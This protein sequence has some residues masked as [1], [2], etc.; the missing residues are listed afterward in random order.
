KRDGRHEHGDEY[1]IKLCNEGGQAE[2][3]EQDGEHRCYATQHRQRCA[4][5]AHPDEL[6]IVVQGSVR[7]RGC[8]GLL[9]GGEDRACL[10]GPC[11]IDAAGDQAIKRFAHRAHRADLAFE[12]TLLLDR[13]LADV[14]ATGGIAATQDKE[15][16]YLCEREAALLGLFNKAQ[17]PGGILVV[18]PVPG[19]ALAGRLDQTLALVITQRVAPDARGGGELADGEHGAVST[20]SLDLGGKTK[21]KPGQAGDPTLAATPGVPVRRPAGRPHRRRDWRN[22]RP[23]CPRSPPREPNGC[24]GLWHAWPPRPF[25]CRER[26]PRT[27]GTRRA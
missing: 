23:A 24:R 27:R 2:R 16:A 7:P 18:K 9:K 5:R 14:P 17:T 15:P 8:L 3:A 4:R 12:L 26:S 1:V 25:A 11:F 22:I 20:V 21:V 13:A 10:D 19:R 6:G